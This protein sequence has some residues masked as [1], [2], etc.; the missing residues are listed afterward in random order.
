M[1]NAGE[2]KRA[3]GL[4]LMSGITIRRK[5]DMRLIFAILFFVGA[6]LSLASTQ[7][8]YA[9][10]ETKNIKSLAP[11][12]IAALLKGHGMGFA[13]AAE[14]NHYPGPRHVLD[15]TEQLHLSAHQIEQTN[16]IFEKMREKAIYLGT[17]LVKYEEELDILFSSKQI[18]ASTLDPLLLKIGKT[19]AML[20]GTHLLAHLKMKNVLSHHQVKMYDSLRGYSSGSGNHNHAH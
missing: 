3:V 1:S 8:P 13:K 15:L 14:L 7:S 16:L 10:E 6:N 12:E 4:A 20:R 19:R 2:Q 11:D 17:Q 5:I 9:G 18:S